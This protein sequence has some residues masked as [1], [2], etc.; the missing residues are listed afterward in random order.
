MLFSS[1]FRRSSRKNSRSRPPRRARLGVEKLEDRLAP[2]TFTVITSG[3]NGDNVNP[4]AG[5]LR[6]AILLANANPGADIIDFNIPGVGVKTISPTK[7]LPAV[8]GQTTIDGTTQG[9]VFLVP[10]IELDG[11]AAGAGANGLKITGD[12]SVIRGLTINDFAANGIW[13]QASNCVVAHSFIGTDVLGGAAAPNQYGVRITGANNR[14]GGTGGGGDFNLISG[15]TINGVF[16]Q[17][18]GA[19]DNLVQGN[20]VGINIA[21][22][23]AVANLVAGIAIIGGAANNTVGGTVADARNVISG[24]VTGVAIWDVGTSGNLVRGNYIGLNPAGTDAIGNG[25]GVAIRAGA[26]NNRVGGAVAGAGNV[27]SGNV[28]GVWITDAGTSGNVVRGNLIGL[29]AAGTAK[30]GNTDGVVMESGA[31]NNTV[32]GTTTAARNVI[33]GNDTGVEIEGAGTSG[34]AV[35]GNYVGLNA[36]G[37]AAIGNNTGVEI[38]DVA[39][40]NSGAA[41]NSVG[42]TVAGAGNVISGNSTGVDIFGIGSSGNLVQG[43]YIGVDPSGTSAIANGD[44][45]IIHGG[46]SNNTVGGTVAAA[47]NI[48]SGNNENGV[49][50]Y[51]LG[52]A[53][54]LVRGNYIGLNAAGTAAVGSTTYGVLIQLGA[55]NNRVGGVAAGAGNVISGNTFGVEIDDDAS[56]GNFVRGNWIG[57]NAAGTAAVLNNDGVY[58]YGGTNNTIGGTVAGARN[59]ISG[60][61]SYGVVIAL[62]SSGNLVQGNYLGLNPA[63]TKAIGNGLGG[64]EILGT[65][66]NNTIGGTTAGAGN[67]IS[68]NDTGVL[69]DQDSAA[70]LVQG[71][72]IGLN[73]AGTKGI[74]NATGVEIDT[75]AAFNTIGGTSASARNVISGNGTGVLIHGSDTSDNTVSGNYIG[76][77]PAGTKNIGNTEGV[78]LSV[79]GP[80][81]TIGGSTPGAGNVIAG[82]GVGVDITV[83]D[84]NAVQGNLIG[85]AADGVTALGNTFGVEIEE[86]AEGNTVGGTSASARNVIAANDIGVFITGNGTSGNAV[87]GNWIGVAADG[88][89]ARGNTR[90]GVF[91]TDQAAGNMIGGT[92]AGAGNLITNSGQDGVL[93]GSDP[94]IGQVSLAGSGNSVLRNRIFNNGGQ[95]IDLGPN[96]GLTGNDLNDTD[97]GPND[98]LNFPVLNSAKLQNGMLLLDG[99]LNTEA[100]KTL[101]IE[102]FVSPSADANGFGEG[103]RYLGFFLV[104][105]NNGLNP[106]FTVALPVANVQVGQVITLTATDDLGNTSEFS[107]AK[108]VS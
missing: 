25:Q 12:G 5:S 101:R 104:T 78:W 73:A 89:T 88:V 85:L 50:I 102:V 71:N 81:N 17:G 14:V 6:Q 22:T 107:F 93:I 49:Y 39:A 36:A 46:A 43:N 2:A 69:I 33:S 7:A 35:Q 105:T 13:L 94:G 40:N 108:A 29:N 34:N 28:R 15:N 21:G 59:V 8:T 63:G 47:R 87:Q 103:K 31:K 4:L 16:I 106:T 96:D 66:T 30:I 51:G 55:S 24:N 83:G 11:S 19:H 42:G 20:Y 79:S 61:G 57:L 9:G 27:I 38:R 91:I 72:L 54:N 58:I 52:T 99:F 45:V 53:G 80:N 95:G 62:F 48:I 76:L 90:H 3:D 18:S 60:N 56:S 23:A 44:G 100:G 82:N 10:A 77:D 37:T 84:N 65:S 1:L 26:T 98:L 86:G 74:A 64:V 92:A 68:G 41:N 70:N 75:G 97:S 32:G 67:V